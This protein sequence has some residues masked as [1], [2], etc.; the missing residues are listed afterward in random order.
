M[1]NVVKAIKSQL[2]LGR[3]GE[4]FLLIRILGNLSEFIPISLNFQRL[5]GNFVNFKDKDEIYE[6][7]FSI[8]FYNEEKVPNL[9]GE[10][11][12]LL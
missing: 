6:S 11:E 3:Q 4:K 8:L 7:L 12:R 1:N 10:L 9:K 5:N 2:R